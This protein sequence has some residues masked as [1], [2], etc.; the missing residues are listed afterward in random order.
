MENME[1]KIINI[2]GKKCILLLLKTTLCFKI[3]I[4]VI[5]HAAN[6][7]KDK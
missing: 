1:L 3:D 5:G 2:I 7:V 6:I 4:N